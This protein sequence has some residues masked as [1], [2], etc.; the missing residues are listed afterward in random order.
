MFFGETMTVYGLGERLFS[1]SFNRTKNCFDI[2]IVLTAIACNE[3]PAHPLFGANVKNCIN[4][5]FKRTPYPHGYTTIVVKRLLS[6]VANVKLIFTFTNVLSQSN[7]HC[8]C[9]LLH[10]YLILSVGKED[11][12][13]L[14][15]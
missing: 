1:N 5:F 6:N 13:L 12:T 3:I 2:I 7:A 14:Y 8:L 9:S 11:I 15:A 10:S 4:P